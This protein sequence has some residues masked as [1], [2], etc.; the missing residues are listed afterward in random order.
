[1]RILVVE[2]Q[3]ELNKIIVKMLEKEGHEVCP[4]YTGTDALE[5]ALSEGFDVIVLDIMLPGITGIECL[6]RIRAKGNETPTLLLTALDAVEDKVAGLNAGAD[7][8]LVKPFEFTELIARLNAITRRSVTKTSEPVVLK[9]GDLEL[10][11]DARTVIRGGKE[12]NLTAKEY[13][14]LEYLLINQGKVISRENLSVHVWKYD[15][16]SG[17]N[18]I[19]VYVHHL[20]KKI[21]E[22]F[23]EKLIKTVKGAGY[24]IR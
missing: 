24:V 14:I 12:I 3:K 4:C 1:M 11:Q 2:D 21:D 18:V 15:Y 19:D 16:D 20:R 9:A 13:E 23:D 5:R 22:G 8:Y 6:K 7:D 17:S 10:N